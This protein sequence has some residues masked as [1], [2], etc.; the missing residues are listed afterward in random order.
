MAY[1]PPQGPCEDLMSAVE[2]LAD[3]QT[4]ADN[5]VDTIFECL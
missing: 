4:G 2:L 1:A 5:L 3:L